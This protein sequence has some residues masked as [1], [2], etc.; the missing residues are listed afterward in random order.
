[1]YKKKI[2]FILFYINF[3]G[4]SI[5]KKAKKNITIQYLISCIEEKKS[6][7]EKNS[8]L[9][10]KK[11][12]YDLEPEDNSFLFSKITKN[13]IFSI[14]YSC[15]TRELMLTNKEIL[16]QYFPDIKVLFNSSCYNLVLKKSFLLRNLLND[17]ISFKK[18]FPNLKL[19]TR[20]YRL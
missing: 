16:S 15:A 10:V 1:M 5:K 2:I 8:S 20:E 18:K 17:Y 14:Q 9:D 7:T 13:K 19:V 6:L 4:C 12:E 11:K 3:L